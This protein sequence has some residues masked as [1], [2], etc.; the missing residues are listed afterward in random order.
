MRGEIKERDKK[1]KNKKQT[2]KQTEVWDKRNKRKGLWS[3]SCG[4]GGDKNY[5]KL[6]YLKFL[7]EI[8]SKFKL[9]WEINK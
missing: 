6:I 7:L 2:N 9:L 5:T 3:Q 4:V 8:M 1:I